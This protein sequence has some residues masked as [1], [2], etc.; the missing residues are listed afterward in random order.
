MTVPALLPSPLVCKTACGRGRIPRIA[1]CSRACGPAR[2]I[3]AKGW[4]KV[5]WLA[6]RVELPFAFS[7]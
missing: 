6:I 4:S 3:N 1:R 7:I 2:K 5:M